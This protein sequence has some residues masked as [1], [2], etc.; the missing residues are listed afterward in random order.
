MKQRIPLYRAISLLFRAIATCTPL[1]HLL[2]LKKDESEGAI[3]TLLAKLKTCTEVYTSR[4]SG[5][6]NNDDVEFN[7]FIEDVKLTSLLVESATCQWSEDNV[8][9]IADP[10]ATLAMTVE[11]KYMKVL[12]N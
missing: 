9:V 10:T 3:A 8:L 5:A 12:K 6:A 2:I 1:L 11:D 4:M 7:F